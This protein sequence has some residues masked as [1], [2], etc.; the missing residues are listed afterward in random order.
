MAKLMYIIK[1]NFVIIMVMTMA[2]LMKFQVI[3]VHMFLDPQI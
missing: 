2:M 3:E 1:N